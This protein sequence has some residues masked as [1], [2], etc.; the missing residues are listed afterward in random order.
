[1]KC[2]NPTFPKHKFDRP[3]LLWGYFTVTL[4]LII[5]KLEKAYGEN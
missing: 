3:A 5:R 1:M 4:I 2:H